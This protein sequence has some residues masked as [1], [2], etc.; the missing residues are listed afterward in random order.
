MTDF[1]KEKSIFIM[2]GMLDGTLIFTLKMNNQF[3]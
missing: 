1:M 3:I 2:D